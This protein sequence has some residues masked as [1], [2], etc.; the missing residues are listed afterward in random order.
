[1]CKKE[2]IIPSRIISYHLLLAALATSAYAAGDRNLT[3]NRVFPS[4]SFV[5]NSSSINASSG[6]VVDVTKFPFFATPNDSTDDTA[7]IQAAI[8]WAFKQL[9]QYGW[10]RPGFSR[11]TYGGCPIIYIPN[12]EYIISDLLTPTQ[13]FTYKVLETGETKTST[14]RSLDEGLDLSQQFRICGQSRSEWCSVLSKIH[15]RIIPV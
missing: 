12:G 15:L 2:C 8:N 7:A 3:E 14:V 5:N 6:S 11:D 9:D 10:Q 1:M 13:A 4:I